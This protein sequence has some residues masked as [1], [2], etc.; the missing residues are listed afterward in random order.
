MCAICHTPQNYPQS[1]ALLSGLRSAPEVTVWC[2]NCLLTHGDCELGRGRVVGRARFVHDLLLH[3][4][5]GS[6]RVRFVPRLRARRWLVDGHEAPRSR[7]Q[8]FL[9]RVR[10]RRLL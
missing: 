2:L 3:R 7:S 1:L 4:G 8:F 5:G 10:V 9:P 6:A